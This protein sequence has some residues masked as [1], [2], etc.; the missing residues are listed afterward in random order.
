[1]P[2][3]MLLNTVY[4]RFQPFVLVRVQF[5]A[6]QGASPALVLSSRHSHP[7][8]EDAN[9]FFAP[10]TSRP[11]TAVAAFNSGH[12]ILVNQNSSL[13]RPST[14]AV[15]SSLSARF[16]AHSARPGT[17][18]ATTAMT[19][20][21]PAKPKS[22]PH[23]SSRASSAANVNSVSKGGKIRIAADTSSSS[24]GSALADELMDL[25]H[26][27]MEAEYVHYKHL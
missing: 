6:L 4:L 1:M 23:S 3:I 10:S 15:D 24:Y 13:Q 2:N 17:T 19:P 27:D 7:D 14:A 21:P 22:I 25:I 20:T 5:E 16:A 9:P 26:D 18:P 12:S 8:H 11:S